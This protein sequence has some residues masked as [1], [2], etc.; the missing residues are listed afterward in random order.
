MRTSTPARRRSAPATWADDGG[1]AARCL[2]AI[3][4]ARS[5]TRL[6]SVARSAPTQCDLR[7]PRNSQGQPV[8]P[9]SNIRGWLTGCFRK[10]NITP[11]AMQYISIRGGLD[12][13]TKVTSVSTRIRSSILAA[14]HAAVGRGHHDLRG[15][16]RWCRRQVPVHR[17]EAW[18][19]NVRAVPA[20]AL[21][22]RAQ[23]RAWAFQRA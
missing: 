2:V 21:S 13:S 10:W 7:F 6:C 12:S 23:Q 18:R 17:A 22:L 4:Q 16:W 19:R 1:P 9:I 5:T 3:H 14:A 20:V 15:H 11:A 8:I